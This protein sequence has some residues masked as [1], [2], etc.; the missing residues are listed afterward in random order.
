MRAIPTSDCDCRETAL[1]GEDEMPLQSFVPKVLPLKWAPGAHRAFTTRADR[2]RSS[3]LTNPRC[4]PRPRRRDPGAPQAGSLDLRPLS[5]PSVHL[6]VNRQRRTGSGFLRQ[7]LLKVQRSSR[8]FLGHATSFVGGHIE[9]GGGCDTRADVV[10]V[11]GDSASGALAGRASSAQ[12][13][14]RPHPPQYQLNPTPTCNSV[15]DPPSYR[16]WMKFPNGVTA[17]LPPV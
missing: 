4:R 9:D 16:V 7:L 17:K 12:M 6:C 10:R 11:S 3:G 1:I 15:V 2:R 13:T 8:R 14:V 5:G